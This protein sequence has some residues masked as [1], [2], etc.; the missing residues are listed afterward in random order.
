MRFTKILC[1]LGPA[2]H[3]RAAIE[4]LAEGGMNVARINLSHGSEDEH[5]SVIHL[6]QEISRNRKKNGK[7]E[8]AILL[9]TKG[10]E[11]RTGDTD[12]PVAIK[13]GQEVIFSSHPNPDADKTVIAVNYGGFANDV[14]ETDRILIDNGEIIFD[15]LSIEK[16]GDVRAKARGDGTIGSRR[17]VNLPGADIDLPSVTERDWEDI[18]FAAEEQVDFLALSFMRTGEDV[19][20]VRNFLQKKNSPI[21]I[22]AKIETKQAVENIQEIIHASDAI[23]IAR[24]DLGAELPFETLPVIQDE[25]VM[26]CRVQ[27]K[28]VIIA[29]HMLESMMHQATPTRAEVTDIAHAATTGADATMLSGETASGSN[30]LLSLDAMDRVLRA[31]EQHLARFSLEGAQ[32]VQSERQ[33]RAEAAKTLADSTHAKAILVFTRTGQTARDL[34]K[35]RPHI[36]IFAFTNSASVARGLQVCYGVVPMEMALDQDPEATVQNALALCK[37]AGTVSPG[38]RVVIVSDAKAHEKLINTVQMRV[39]T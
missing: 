10:A 6:I 36:P 27:G 1:T 5:R 23:M 13:K 11:I 16:N 14:R 19:T 38:D 28:P 26:L 34:A 37:K 25:I 22:I 20:S 21:Q 9:D 31:T 29:T 17:H 24:G 15:I 8:I 39:I 12:K 7:P 4:A 33:A 18:A 35:F 3:T 2:T 32:P 30:P